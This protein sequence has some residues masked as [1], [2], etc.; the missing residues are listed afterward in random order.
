[1]RI[2]VF[3]LLATFCFS[4]AICITRSCSVAAALVILQCFQGL[5][6]PGESS[7]ICDVI[8]QTLDL[9]PGCFKLAQSFQQQASCHDIGGGLARFLSQRENYMCA[10]TSIT[11]ENGTPAS[12][13]L[14]S[15][16]YIILGIFSLSS[17][18]SCSL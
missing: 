16:C 8:R 6:A 4:A 5:A 3:L 18:C 14:W 13:P 1:M 11:Q 10:L 15:Y 9:S 2:Q 17:A 12:C 7:L